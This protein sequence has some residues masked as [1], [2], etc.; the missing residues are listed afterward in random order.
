MLMCVN[1]S[2]LNKLFHT[3]DNIGSDLNIGNFDYKI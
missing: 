1:D 2:K 3:D